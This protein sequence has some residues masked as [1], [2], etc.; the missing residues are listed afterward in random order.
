M[1]LAG[2]HERLMALQ[3]SSAQLPALVDRLAH[4]TFEPGSVPLG[5]EEEDSVSGELS[6]EI[7]LRLKTG[8]EE[9]ELL[10]AEASYA[11]PEGHEKERL[12]DG[13]VRVGADLAKYRAAF[14]KAR[15]QAK[16]SLV[17]A[18]KLERRLLLQSYSAPVPDFEPQNETDEPAA[19][20]HTT[21]RYQQPRS[22]LQNRSGLSETDQQTVGASSNVTASLRRAHDLIASEL[23]RSAYAHETL[24]ESTAALRQLDDSYGSLD[25]MLG[26]SRELL[27]TLLRSQKSDTWYLQTAFYMLAVTLAWL[28]FRR[29]LYGPLWWL[30]LVPLRILLGIGKT[31]TRAVLPAGKQSAAVVQSGAD[32]GGERVSVQG[33]PGEALPTAKVG[34]QVVEDHVKDVVDEAVKQAVEEVEAGQETVTEPVAEK[35]PADDEARGVEDRGD[36]D[37]TNA[38]PV[39][40]KD[41]L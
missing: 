38:E 1:S 36:D 30:V 19:Q 17:E 6:A 3:A 26:K 7:G 33:L 10:R 15:L 11:R 12:V 23:G 4:L 16:K 29:L 35:Q 14:R 13:V 37:S 21:T 24:V 20:Q 41:E 5:T 25:S 34:S 31:A 28:A 39:H 9:Q 18:Q 22:I 8:A 27:G 32:G 2:L 40:E